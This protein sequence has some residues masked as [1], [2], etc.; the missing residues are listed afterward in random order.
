MTI[1]SIVLLGLI[2][3]FFL[4]KSRRTITDIFI[5]LTALA[6]TLEIM[7]S[8]GYFIRIGGFEIGYSELLI[9]IDTVLCIFMMHKKE[10]I[11]MFLTMVY[12]WL[13]LV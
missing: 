9:I 1:F 7:M 5:N 3:V 11:K 6:A 8:V 10:S 13:W 12:Y 2:F 4:K